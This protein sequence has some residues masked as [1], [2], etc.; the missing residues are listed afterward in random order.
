MRAAVRFTLSSCLALAQI[1][2]SLAQEKVQPPKF[3]AGTELVRVDFVVTD[4]AGRIVRGVTAKDCVVKEDGKERPIVSF[5]A[6]DGAG[7]ASAAVS[8]ASGNA[9]APSPASRVTRSSTVLLIDDG[10]LSPEQLAIVR[11]A[12]KQLLAGVAE[13]SGLLALVAPASRVT[14]AGELPGAAAQL[15]AGADAIA[16]KRLDDHSSF[17]VL[18]AEAIA[19]NRGDLQVLARVIARFVLLNP[20]LTAD[21]ADMLAHSRSTDVEFDARMRR[22][23]VIAAALQSLN[24]LS[25]KPG[26]HSLIMVSGGYARDPL[27]SQQAAL[28]TRSLQVNAPI[29]FLDARGLSGFGMFHGAQYGVALGRNA[30]EGPY[31]RDEAVEGS[32]Y[33]ADDTGGTI[34]HNTNDLEK[35]LAGMLDAM[36]TYYVI[37]YEAPAHAKRGFH[38]IEVQVR[39]KGLN[40]RARRG[41]Y[42]ATGR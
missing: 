10:H 17:P 3:T 8:D 14:I 5:E 42:D 27:D 6:F 41:Y 20:T 18:D 34:V 1:A 13:R 22:E 28:V 29:H 31:A 9:A 39:T 40:V 26:R 4:K 37:G 7:A 25:D 11:P 21:Q 19:I 16:G 2:P 36:Q 38:K 32:S 12:L 33:L 35:G 24:W 23:T 30:D 15:A